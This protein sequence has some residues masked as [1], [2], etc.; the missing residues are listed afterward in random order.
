M[1][2]AILIQFPKSAITRSIKERRILTG[3][4][5]ESI[6]L[7]PDRTVAEHWKNAV[8]CISIADLVAKRAAARKA[9]GTQ[10]VAMES[11]HGN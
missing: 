6:K 7:L 8:F 10:S 5:K 4:F 9:S 11:D 3:Y 1:A 2:S